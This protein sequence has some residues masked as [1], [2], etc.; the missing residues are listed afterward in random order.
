MESI[1]SNNIVTKTYLKISL[2][3][4]VQMIA[5]QH[6]ATARAIPAPIRHSHTLLNDNIISNTSCLYLPPH[7][8]FTTQLTHPTP[9]PP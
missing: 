4:A 5:P 2:T 3:S 8:P 7:H 1:H 6:A 9:A